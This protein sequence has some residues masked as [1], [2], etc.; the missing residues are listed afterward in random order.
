MIVAGKLFDNLE[1]YLD[2]EQDDGSLLVLPRLLCGLFAEV[3]DVYN[4]YDFFG[5][6]VFPI[7]GSNFLRR[8]LMRL[9]T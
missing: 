4:E 2:A 7:A 3:N 6:S 8:N 9:W 1:V 5:Y